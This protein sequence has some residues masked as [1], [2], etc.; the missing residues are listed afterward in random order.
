M[1]VD[2]SQCPYRVLPDIGMSVIEASLCSGEERFDELGLSEFGQKS[3]SV[4]SNE[5]VGML[6]VVPDAIAVA[7]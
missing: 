2:R 5:F 7:N 1:C 6:Q 3:Q 4:A